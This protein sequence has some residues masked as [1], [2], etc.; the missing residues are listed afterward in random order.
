MIPLALLACLSRSDPPEP[1]ESRA[2]RILKARALDPEE[3]VPGRFKSISDT[4]DED[5]QALAALGYVDGTMPPPNTHGARVIDA[6]AIQP[7]A[8][9]YVSG[10]G[11][12]A[13]LID[14]DGTVLH[15]WAYDWFDQWPEET[16]RE[17]KEFPNHWR[18]AHLYE[19]GDLLVIWG[20]QGMAKIDKDSRFLWGTSERNVH[21]DIDVAPDGSVWTLARE[22]MRLPELAQNAVVMDTVLVFEPD[23]AVR[24]EFSVFDCFL[25]SE[26]RRWISTFGKR[27]DILHTNTITILGEGFRRKEFAAGNLLVSFRNTSQLAVIDPRAKSVVWMLR[28]PWI[29][30]HQPV[31]L[32]DDLVL[33][34]DN[35]GLETRSRVLEASTYS[36]RETWQYGADDGQYF[37]SKILGS[38]QRLDN[39]NTLI[40]ESDNGRAFEITRDGKRVWEFV[41]PHRAGDHD[42]FIASLY[43][44]VRLPPDFDLSWA[45][46]ATAAKS[47]RAQGGPGE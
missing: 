9:L 15:K 42:Q 18:R 3:A 35:R 21:H 45:D 26:H 47:V 38:V 7:G 32:S 29:A 43:E 37:W 34:F 2:D 11:P 1:P 30:Q 22:P 23:G 39:G 31:L 20:G 12:E 19:N 6:D 25:N 27:G 4:P 17:H 28:G 33:L 8:N 40:T 14:R 5:L 13:H 41:N 16:G 46:P 36:G 10:Q 24:E 44:L